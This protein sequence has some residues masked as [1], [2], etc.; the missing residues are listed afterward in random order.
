MKE[1]EINTEA[2]NLI[3]LIT[4]EKI[5]T[6]KNKQKPDDIIGDS[7]G[8]NIGEVQNLKIIQADLYG[9]VVARYIPQNNNKIGFNV[10]NYKQLKSLCSEIH[11]IQSISKFADKKFIETIIFDWIMEI[12]LSK[13]AK[14]ELLTYIKSCIEIEFD[15]FT[16]YYK[17]ECL[18]IS[19][20][21]LIGDVKIDRIQKNLLDQQYNLENTNK[22]IDRNEF[23]KRYKDFLN[24]PIASV[25]IKAIKN[26]SEKLSR[27]KIEL[28]LNA[29][30]CFLYKESIQSSIKIFD[31]DFLFRN[32]SFSNYLFHSNKN[33]EHLNIGLRRE[34]GSLPTSINKNILNRLNIDGFDK[35]CEF[36]ELQ[37]KNELSYFIEDSINSLG[38]IISTRDWYERVIR[39]ISFFEN[40]IVPK[41]NTKSNGERYLKRYVLCKLVNKDSEK[42][43]PLIRHLYDTRD[44]YLHNRI[45]KPIDINELYQT[46]K[47]C[48]IFLLQLIELNKKH[49]SIDE[50]LH[51][52]GII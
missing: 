35:V 36:L 8:I 16:F 20:P 29:I 25:Q 46:Q 5:N 52:Y 3:N 14:N 48:L 7:K 1:S 18:E 15:L 33:N 38:E 39:I 30:K 40:I 27:K 2:Y 31:V 4:E 26:S 19:Q 10:E 51:Y 28:A 21:I 47:L 42:I 11:S 13:Q 34:D 50:V 6:N 43:K 17:I 12:Y 22:P 9:N 45:L 44:K 37:E 49:S 32:L 41:S 24:K 23:N